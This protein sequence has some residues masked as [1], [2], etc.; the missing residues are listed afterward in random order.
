[1]GAKDLVTGVWLKPV[2]NEEELETL[3]ALELEEEW[4]EWQLWEE[5]NRDAELFLLNAVH[6]KYLG[7]LYDCKDS[8]TMWKQLLVECEK[9]TLIKSTIALR[10]AQYQ[11]KSF[12][13]K[14]GT[15]LRQHFRHMEDLEDEVIREGGYRLTSYLRCKTL[16]ESLSMEYK[17]IAEEL[18]KPGNHTSLTD[19]KELKDQLL[20]KTKYKPPHLRRDAEEHTPGGTAARVKPYN[21]QKRKMEQK[22]TRQSSPEKALKNVTCFCC[23]EKGHFATSCPQKTFKDK[24][25]NWVKRCYHCRRTDHLAIDCPHKV[26]DVEPEVRSN[27]SARGRPGAYKKLKREKGKQ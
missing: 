14:E 8:T 19:Y 25:G 5:I 21:L 17:G 12:R 4:V 13:M 10:K 22:K 18:Q 2:M 9:K 6:K 27:P 11:Y 26:Q 23:N 1:M 7:C 24:D 15:D 20:K 3:D 16:L